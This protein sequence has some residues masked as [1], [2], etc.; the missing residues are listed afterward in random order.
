ADGKLYR[1]KWV[2]EE[3]ESWVESQG[4]SPDTPVIR[5]LPLHV[6]K[7]LYTAAASMTGSEAFLTTDRYFLFRALSTIQ[8]DDDG[9]PNVYS[10]IFGGLYYQLAGI[11][12]NFK[13]GTDLDNILAGLGIGNVEQ[14]ITAEKVFAEI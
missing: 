2:D 5:L 9:K 11:G 12:T 6:D 3:I 4:V 7:A 10:T 8:D 13:K 1:G 14:G